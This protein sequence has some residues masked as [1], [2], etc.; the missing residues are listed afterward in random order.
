MRIVV[1]FVCFYLLPIL[2]ARSTTKLVFFF[3]GI[4]LMGTQSFIRNS[5]S[6]GKAQLCYNI[7][8]C[9]KQWPQIGMTLLPP[10]SC[11]KIETELRVM[12][13]NRFIRPGVFTNYV[14]Q[15]SRSAAAVQC[16]AVFRCGAVCCCCKCTSLSES[17]PEPVMW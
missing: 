16:T 15:Y 13:S 12:L 17:R 6:N 1:L 7:S 9:A 8:G 11:C 2:M 4:S 5:L 3:S 10:E 14:Q